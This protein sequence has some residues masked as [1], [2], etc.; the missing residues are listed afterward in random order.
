VADQH[1]RLV[2]LTDQ[3]LIVVDDLRHAETL[4][5][6]GRFTKLLDIA[7]LP[8]PLRGREVVPALLEVRHVVL[9][10]SRREPG[11]VDQ[12]HRGAVV[13]GAGGGGHGRSSCLE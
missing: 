13:I 3:L 2:E 12:H 10:A 1:G 7:V 6:P 9:P 5:L 4:D 8:G 11:S